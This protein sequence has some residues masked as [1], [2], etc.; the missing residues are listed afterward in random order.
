MGKVGRKQV[1]TGKFSMG[2]RNKRL[3]RVFD[4]AI[5]GHVARG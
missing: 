1:E 3:K 5:A 4:E 2:R